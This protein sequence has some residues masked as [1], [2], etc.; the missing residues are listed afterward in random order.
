MLPNPYRQWMY[1]WETRLTMRDTN[2]VVRPLE[3][4]ADWAERWPLVNGDFRAAGGDPERFLHE[5]NQRI[6]EHSDEFFSYR[7]PQDFRLEE[8]QVCH[9][10]TDSRLEPAT[11]LRFTSEVETPYAENNLVNARWFQARAKTR[12]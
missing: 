3:W 5:L 12:P 6:V 7:T 11:F 4:G 10:K 9:G 2:R 1:G 8:R